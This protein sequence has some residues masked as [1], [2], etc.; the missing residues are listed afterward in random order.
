M[1]REARGARM[2]ALLEEINPLQRMVNSPGMDRAFEIFKR[3]FPDAVIHEYPAGM[4]CED[5]IVPRSWRVISGS[6]KNKQ[7]D[8]I[9]S[10]DESILFVAPYSEPVNGWF[11]KEEIEKHLFT[12]EDRPNSFLL[13]HRHTYNYQLVDWG[14]TLPF[15]LWEDLSEDS[16]HIEIDVD[17]GDGS[18]KVGEYFLPGFRDETICICAHI[19][20]LCN[21]DLSGCIL[22]MELMR[23]LEQMPD[24]QYSYQLLWVPEMFGPLFFAHENPSTIS[25]TIVMLNL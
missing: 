6:M 5:W 24:R 20:E 15:N 23:T 16:Y 10:I 11:S 8:I 9:A 22:G 2:R 25:N 4:E 19:D 3:E 17:W 14:I 21:D 18:M 13:Q 1:Q 12:R 7:G